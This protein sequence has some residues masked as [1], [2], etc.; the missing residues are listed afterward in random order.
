MMRQE[1]PEPS[2][3]AITCERNFKVACEAHVSGRG[4]DKTNNKTR[5]RTLVGPA[6]NRG[7]KISSNKG[8]AHKGK[9]PRGLNND[10]YAKGP[11]RIKHMQNLSASQVWRASASKLDPCIHRSS[12]SFLAQSSFDPLVLEIQASKLRNWE[13]SDGALSEL[14]ADD[15]ADLSIMPTMPY[16]SDTL[17]QPDS[18]PEVSD[19][20]LSSLSLNNLLPL[21]WHR[22]GDQLQMINTP[23]L[24]ETSKWSKFAMMKACKALGVN[25]TGFEHEILD[26]ILRMEERR[27]LQV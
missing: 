19:S 26:I 20:G 25:V 15:E 21:P 7:N 10:C 27:K 17:I 8:K 12:P 4:A 13:L 2:S 9:A 11:T 3:H 18:H 1:V 6:Q 5:V 23:E 14:E 16:R 22:G 24:V